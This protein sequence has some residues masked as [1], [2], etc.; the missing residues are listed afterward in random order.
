MPKLLPG[1]HIVFVCVGNR[2]R[3]PL[4]AAHFAQ[5]MRLRGFDCKIESAGTMVGVN[6]MRATLV[7][8]Q[9]EETRGYDLSKHR[10]RYI[11]TLDLTKDTFLACLDDDS[12]RDVRC[13]P[14]IEQSRVRLLY[15]TRGV[16][17]PSDNPFLNAYREC[18]R[19]IDI[20]IDRL[21]EEI[22]DP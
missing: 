18:F 21:I 19:Q 17:D 11:G 8:S 20:G 13:S 9:L 1:G 16:F 3:S 22:I 4:A 5:K 14:I 15:S 6:G 7:W 12:E 2:T 10:S